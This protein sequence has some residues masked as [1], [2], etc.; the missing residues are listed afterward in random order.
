ML[1]NIILTNN[2]LANNLWWIITIAVAALIIII[3]IIE[4][5]LSKRKAKKAAQKKQIAAQGKYLTY[6][7]GASN[8]IDSSLEG[9]RIVVHLYDYALID[10][11]KLKEA[12]VTGFIEKSDKLTL[13]VPNN[14]QE[15]YNGIFKGE[16]AL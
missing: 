8:V 4:V 14:S 10:R 15:I 7:G 1:T 2:F 5:M 11:E 13:V 16:D 6:L 3:V 9:S 12:G